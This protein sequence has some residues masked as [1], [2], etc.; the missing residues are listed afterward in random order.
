MNFH[1]LTLFPEMIQQGMN[2]SIIGRAITGGYLSV[3]AINIR[4]YAFNKH[5]KVDDYPYG[6]GAGMLMQAEPVYLAYQ[7]IE[8]KIG[9]RPRVVYLTPQGS[10][11]NQTM[12]KDFAKEKDLVFLCGHYEGIDER[13]LE[14]VV[15]DLVSIGDYV[16]TGGELPA[17]VMM[18]SISRMVPGVLSNQESGETESFAGNLLEYPQYSRPEEWHGKKVPPVLLS[19]H[20]A[21]I[22]AWRREQ[23]ILRTA[24]NRPDLLKKADLTNKEWNQV[25]QWRKQWKEEKEQNDKE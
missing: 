13:V 7:S 21:N 14:E 19:G 12:A 1:V 17:M 23:S 20:H 6:G 9:Y 22:E 25:R 15:T 24:K 3:E 16:L 4:D 11:F 10:V 2:T 18:D 8:E 5:Q